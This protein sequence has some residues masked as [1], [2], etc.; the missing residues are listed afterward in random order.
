MGATPHNEGGNATYYTVSYGRIVKRVKE[1]T[2]L[3]KER[4]NTKGNTVHEEIFKDVSGRIVSANLKPGK[5]D[6]KAQWQIRLEDAQGEVSVLSLDQ[7]SRYVTDLGKKLPNIDMGREVVLAPY[8]F[9]DPQTGKVR[10]G[11]TVYQGGQKIQA[12]FTKD[13]AEQLPQMVQMTFKGKQVWD[14]TELDKAI[15]S[16]IVKYCGGVNAQSSAP[17]QTN[18]P[19]T[20]DDIPF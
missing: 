11:I 13:S 15:D 3:S 10:A 17:A 2:A 7:G 16:L 1:P 5:D 18:Q 4:V 14:T 9:K 6:F 20:N 8:D 19:D 12:A